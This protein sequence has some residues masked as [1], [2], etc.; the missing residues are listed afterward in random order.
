M[1]GQAVSFQSRSFGELAHQ[2]SQIYHLLG[3]I[4]GREPTSGLLERLADSTTAQAFAAY[5]VRYQD[6]LWQR[7]LNERLTELEVEYARLFLG[8]GPHLALQESVARGEGQ[9]WG[10]STGDVVASYGRSGY[11][12]DASFKDLPDHLSAELVFVACLA[13]EESRCWG[14][15][16]RA[17]A[18][19]RV[20][21]QLDFL[22]AHPLAWAPRLVGDVHR[23]ARHSFYKGFG[24]LLSRVLTDD[25]NH[26]AEL[27]RSQTIPPAPRE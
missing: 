4:F 13:E 21:D 2:R 6:E 12:V 8:P 16:Q 11:N 19:Q 3:R 26:L 15:G 5:G 25:V 20:Q 27:L 22:Q 7:P 23:Q 17:A 18:L 10:Q 1:S 24:T 14:A 9:F